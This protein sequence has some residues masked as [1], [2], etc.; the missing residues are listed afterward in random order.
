MLSKKE[1]SS[2]CDLLSGKLFL[3]KK[4]SVEDQKSKI[5]VYL[6]AFL[7]HLFSNIRVSHKD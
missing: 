6:L 1:Q 7:K 5:A 2:S 3:K 4:K